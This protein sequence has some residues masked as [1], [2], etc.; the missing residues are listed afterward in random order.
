MKTSIKV[1]KGFLATFLLTIA[2]FSAPEMA[3][4]HFNTLPGPILLEA[5]KALETNNIVPLLKRVSEDDQATIKQIFAEA[6]TVRTQ[7]G[8]AKVMADNYFLETLAKLIS[9]GEG[10]HFAPPVDFP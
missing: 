6:L 10:S 7:S 1:L 9:D 4:A 5:K 2:V 3:Q 8:I